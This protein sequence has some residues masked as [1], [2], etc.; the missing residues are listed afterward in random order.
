MEAPRKAPVRDG[1]AGQLGYGDGGAYA[2]DGLALDSGGV[3]RQ[4]LLAAAPEHEGVPALEPD[5][6]GKP[7]RTFDQHAVYL[8]LP[9]RVMPGPFADVDEFGLRRGQGEDAL[10]Y[11]VVVNKAVAGGYE[12]ACAQ[13]EQFSTAAARAGE[14]YL[15]EFIAHL[16]P[17]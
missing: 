7:A 10:V 12:L 16:Q 3:Q 2:R 17:P 1:Y 14:I 15:S 6:F 11:E 5:D 8:L 9:H 4:E 13:R